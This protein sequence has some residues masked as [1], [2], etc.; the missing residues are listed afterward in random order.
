MKF[1]QNHFVEDDLIAKSRI[2]SAYYILWK[3]L[4]DKYYQDVQLLEAKT[5]ISLKNLPAVLRKE[6]IV[7]YKLKG[8]KFYYKRK[9]R[10]KKNE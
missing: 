2:G 1:D 10:K 4:D 9:T 3:N 7:D 6:G 5:K 8:N